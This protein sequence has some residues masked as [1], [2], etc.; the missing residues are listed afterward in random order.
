MDLS[1]PKRPGSATTSHDLHAVDLL[2]WPQT[3]DVKVAFE[4]IYAHLMY[5]IGLRDAHILVIAETVCAD[6]MSD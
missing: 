5:F 4:K 1:A 3:A 2:V 6:T